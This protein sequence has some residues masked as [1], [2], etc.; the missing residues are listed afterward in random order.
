[1]SLRCFGWHGSAGMSWKSDA[2]TETSRGSALPAAQSQADPRGI[3]TVPPGNLLAPILPMLVWVGVCLA[4]PVAERPLQPVVQPGPT[5]PAVRGPWPTEKIIHLALQR[6]LR[7]VTLECQLTPEEAGVFQ[8]E[9]VSRWPA[10][11]R[12]YRPLLQPVVN[13]FLE[14]TISGDPPTKEQ[15][16]H[17]AQ[18]FEPVVRA[19]RS[20]IDATSQSVRK[21]LRPAQVKLWDEY[22]SRLWKQYGSVEGELRKL[23]QGQFD[24][25][26]WQVVWSKPPAEA[27]LPVGVSV[28][29]T[30]RPAG[31]PTDG[32]YSGQPRGA[33]APV[34]TGSEHSTAD[35]GIPG[36]RRPTRPLDAWEQYVRQFIDRY[37]LDPGQANAAMS[38][39]KDLQRRSAEYRLKH[40]QEIERL[41]RL[42]AAADAE[43]RPGIQRKLDDLL[44]PANRL[45]DELRSRLDGL[46]TE[47]QRSGAA[48]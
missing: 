38:V 24:P 3:R 44:A 10:F 47:S 41:E 28:S 16:T 7:E 4:Q 5:Q 37:K 42:L 14:V 46:L 27:R 11:A 2:G 31:A 39:L 43:A 15:V 33:V 21:I 17:W 32:R 20:E 22:H 45:F 25:R 9:L 36:S 40:R 23:A 26:T 19:A 8:K 13:E 35:G 48:P 18:V 6:I 12:K 30:T 29:P 34:R 1:M